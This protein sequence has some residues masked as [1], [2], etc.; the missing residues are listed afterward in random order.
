L[1]IFR[2]ANGLLYLLY[3]RKRRMY[4]EAP[5]LECEPLYHNVVLKKIKMKDFMEVS[6][7]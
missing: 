1:T 4:T 2:H 6:Y 5:Q 3:L 7:K